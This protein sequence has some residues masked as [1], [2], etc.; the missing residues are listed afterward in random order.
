MGKETDV[1]PIQKFMKL[2]L[3]KQG[4]N[5]GLKSMDKTHKHYQANEY[6]ITMRD[7]LL[8]QI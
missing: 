2:S 1:D 6:R 3:R 8:Y 7:G 5:G 4:Q